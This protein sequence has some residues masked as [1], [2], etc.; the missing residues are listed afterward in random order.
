MTDPHPLRP[1][2]KVTE[3]TKNDHPQSLPVATD[4]ADQDVVAPV[5]HYTTLTQSTLRLNLAHAEVQRDLLDCQA[6]HRRVMRMFAHVNAPRDVNEILYR[7]DRNGPHWD[8]IVQSVAVA[9][10]QVLPAGYIATVV[11]QRSD[12]MA[13]LQRLQVGQRFLFG[14]VANVSKRD[15]ESRKRITVRGFDAQREWLLRKGLDHGFTLIEDDTALV[16]LGI[17]AETA[18]VGNHRNG[19]LLFVPVRFSGTLRVIHP[20]AFAQAVV[21]GIGSAKAYGCGLLTVRELG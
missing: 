21:Q 4:D 20:Q 12:L 10:P 11:H 7:I 18:L 3:V 5:R 8:L 14:L 16:P 1:R 13:Q 15:N 6:M 2:R 9:D 19:S 17:E